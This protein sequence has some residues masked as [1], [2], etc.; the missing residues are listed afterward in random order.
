VTPNDAKRPINVRCAFCDT[1]NRVDLARATDGPKCGECKRP[2]LLDRPI[3]VS[4]R[5][6]AQTVEGAD[7][8]VLVDFYADWCGPCRMVA[9]FI[10]EIARANVG[11]LLVAKVDTDR[12]QSVAMKYGIR[13][14]PTLVL[15]EDGKEVE[16]SI[17]FEPE[18]LHALVAKAV[19]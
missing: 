14:I 13:S 19:A 1:V 9:P 17:G 8:P 16:R 5:D 10:D 12:A 2:I 4:E 6:F 7:G 18:R 15:F 11:K 3:K